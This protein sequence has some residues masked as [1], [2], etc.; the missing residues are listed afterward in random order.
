MAEFSSA[1]PAPKRQKFTTTRCRLAEIVNTDWTFRLRDLPEFAT[2]IGEH[3]LDNLLD[4]RSP[5]ACERR[6]THARDTAALLEQEFG[7]ARGL[8]AEDT[9]T[10][11]LLLHHCRTHA[12]GGRF[13]QYLCCLNRL[14][15]PHTE[16]PQLFKYMSL[17]SAFQYEQYT[18]R[19]AAIPAQLQQVQAL[20]TQGL[21]EKI[22][23]PLCGLEGVAEQIESI[24]APV[25][26]GS[27]VS[28]SS[29]WHSP[30]SSSYKSPEAEN[31][32]RGKATSNLTTAL[33]AFVAFHGFVKD[34]YIPGVAKL[35]PGTFANPGAGTSC[36]A[37]PD[38]QA[39]YAACLRFHTSS[40]RTA[41]EIHALGCAEV[42]RIG[43]E[44]R[45]AAMRCDLWPAANGDM[46]AFHALLRKD[47]R[48][49]S[50]TP[51]EHVN[52]YRALCKKIDPLL[53]KLF[54][55]LPRCPYGV[56]ATPAGAAA[57]APTAYYL[58]GAGDGTRAGV[59][60]ANTSKLEERP[61]YEA[62]ALTL[63]EA[64]PGHHVQ[65]MLAAEN[66]DLA[67]F[68][69]YMDDR[70]YYEAPGRYPIEGA[71]I[72]G[73]G[74]YS[75][76]LGTELG[77]YKD[78]YQLIGRLSAEMWRATR[79]VVDTGIHAQ[80]WSLQRAADYMEQHTMTSRANIEAEVR[81][82]S[83]WPGQACGYKCGELELKRLRKK[84]EDGWRKAAERA[85]C[86]PKPPPD[87]RKFHN[88]VLLSGAMPLYVLEQVI[89]EFIEGLWRG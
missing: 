46:K 53:C 73:W 57:A 58:G 16:L 48:F 14:E 80:G 70:K 38:G 71:Y 32:A 12:D 26:N 19:L 74:L 55:T 77:V 89:D 40:S 17:E 29:L 82:Y 63:H 27:T 84:F 54:S 50:A 36:F 88:L 31:A 20:L 49:Y 61:W 56:E 9:L 59:F 81:R 37:L 28:E 6:I 10:L 83:T 30:P 51:E 87:V 15:G 8:S 1:P 42:E 11:R 41:A 34:T 76:Y 64:V 45:E 65:T 4:D 68:R 72:E 2:A 22:V 79:L 86:D 24:C 39:M 5:E 25:Q 35:R 66:M 78:P 44:L 3:T 67:P 18:Q 62:E 33:H 7:D 75:E 21:A 43:N 23:P 85:A 60:Y 52:K 47:P 13:R 69:R